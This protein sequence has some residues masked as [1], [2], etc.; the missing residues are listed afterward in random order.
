MRWPFAPRRSRARPTTACTSAL[1]GVDG[2]E[3]L[4]RGAR[5]RRRSGARPSS[6]RCRAGRT[7][8]PSR[9]GPP[10][11]RGAGRAR[12]E[13]CSWPATS[14]SVLRPQSLGERRARRER[15]P[16]RLGE[17]VVHVA[18]A[19]RT[20]G[21]VAMAA[22]TMYSMDAALRDEATKL[23]RDL[24][25]IDTTNPPGH[26][27]PPP[28][29]FLQAFLEREG[30]ACELRRARPRAREPRRAHQGQRRGPVADAA[31]PHRR[32]VR[33]PP[34]T[35]ASTR[36]PAIV[37]DGYVWGRG[38]LDMK[39]Q[40][41]ATRSRSRCS[42]ASGSGAARRSRA[43]RRGRRGGR[44]RRASACRSLVRAAPRPAHRLRDQR[45]ERT[46]RPRRRP[47]SCTCSAGE[48]AT[49]P[50]RVIARGVA[51][52]ASVPTLGRQRAAQARAR[53]RAARRLRA[54]RR[55]VARARRCCSTRSRPGT[56]RSTRASRERPRAAPGA[57]G[58]LLP[59]IAGS[60]LSPTMAA[61]LRKR[62]VIPARGRASSSTA[63][64]CRAPSR[65][66]CWASSATACGGLDVELELAE[67]PD[68]GSRSPLDTP[69]RDALAEYSRA[70]SPARCSCR[71]LSAGLHDSHF[72]R[73]AFG[74]VAYGFF[75]L[76]HTA[77][78]LA[79]HR[80]RA[81]RAH[82]P[83]RPRPWRA[84]PRALHRPDRIGWWHERREAAPR[85]DGAAQRPAAAR[86]D[87]VGGRRARPDGSIR[88]GQRPRPRCRGADRRA[89]RARRRAHGR[90]A[91][92]AADRPA[93][94]ARGAAPVRARR[95]GDRGRP[96]RGAR[97][98]RQAPRARPAA[99]ELGST[100]VGLV[101]PL[102]ALRCREL[103]G[104][105]GAE[106]KAIGGYEH[107]V[108]AVDDR[109]GARA[110]RHAPGRPALSAR[111]RR[112]RLAARAP[113]ALRRPV[114]ALGSLGGDGRRRRGVR[115]GRP[116]PRHAGA[117]RA[118]P[119][120][121][122]LPARARDGGAAAEPSSR[123]PSAPSTGC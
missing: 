21:R 64:S 16:G 25:R 98:G 30:V 54:E 2:G 121:L 19:T 18:D 17:Q 79:R 81:R 4:E 62:N 109:Q 26:E 119:P 39:A 73:E 36:S 71:E 116:H 110:L 103:A 33:R 123:S 90:D 75:P 13:R 82:P 80:P 44:R 120:G 112:R 107:G 91:R 68:G 104:Y 60:T 113:R 89:A 20:E 95:R 14:S 74:T 42:R 1:P 78:E 96:R 41:A 29:C 9:G 51:G 6:C 117:S 84:L 100:L 53:A 55:S 7:G 40:T 47:A 56:R 3:L 34:R 49:M 65:T 105:H 102:V 46:P 85:R 86:P 11:S 45:G 101:P 66:S 94:P 15:A 8:S 106:H 32:R 115:L 28:P 23:L 63:A 99:R 70:S 92:A 12:A 31:R 111:P 118:R 114:G 35:G 61:R 72:L 87:L 22:P 58:D 52:H 27:T 88:V 76:R 10:R 57:A 77:P 59:P 93:A 97:D 67:P 37:R 50:V 5:D 24:I 83:G 48:K 43:D 38:A 108:E 122:R 69:L